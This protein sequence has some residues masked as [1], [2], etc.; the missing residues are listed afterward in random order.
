M[1]EERTWDLSILMK[2]P[3]IEGVTKATDS[4][5]SDLKDAVIKLSESQEKVQPNQLV[6]LIRQF[7][8]SL[9]RVGTLQVYTYCK[10]AVDTNAEDS[11]SLG[12]LFHRMYNLGEAQSLL[13]VKIRGNIIQKNPDIIESPKLID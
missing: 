1:D 3:S 9:E 13:F 2:D 4:A 11:Q 6:K 7:E 12:S 5:I 8:A 10:H